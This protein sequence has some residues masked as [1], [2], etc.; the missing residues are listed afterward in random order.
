MKPATDD[1]N[2]KRDKDAPSTD[3]EKHETYKYPQTANDAMFS[4][5]C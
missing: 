3:T 2:E 4:I 5:A 1:E